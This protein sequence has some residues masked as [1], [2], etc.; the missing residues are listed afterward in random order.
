MAEKADM[1]GAQSIK[2][3]RAPLGFFAV[4]FVTLFVVMGVGLMPPVLPLYAEQWHLSSGQASLLLSA[5]AAG[6]IPISLP[7]GRAADRFG[8]GLVAYSGLTAALVSAVLAIVASRYEHLLL[9]LFLQ[10]LGAGTFTTVSNAAV[11]AVSDRD[12]V[13]RLNSVYQGVILAGLS[14]APVLG[15][16]GAH[17]G[18]LRG[19]FV[20]YL[21]LLGVGVLVLRP[22]ARFMRGRLESVAP[23]APG[24][25]RVRVLLSDPAFRAMLVSSVVVF[26][27]LA[28]IRNAL[29]PLYASEIVGMDGVAIGGMLTASAVANIGIL[30]PAGKAVDLLGRRP[31]LVFGMIG[32][33]CAVAFLAAVSIPLWLIVGSAIVGGAKGI[34]AAPLPPLVADVAPQGM[35]AEAV[36]YYRIAV[37]VGLL[38]GPAVLGATVDAWGFRA[39]FLGAA[40]FLGTVGAL[41]LRMPETGPVK[42][43][44]LFRRGRS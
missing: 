18:G 23:K 27:A 7:V 15:S 24:S 5:F 9:A 29:L 2:G 1:P 17:L 26:A 32:M 3:A 34:A 30:Y 16:V 37:S 40:L 42:Q 35:R 4:C 41:L 6:R 21:A 11:I 19:P 12:T 8:F 33:A 36:G 38:V 43:R 14:F 28:G 39:A 20:V 44:G 22:A 10:G 13:G 31:V 25:S